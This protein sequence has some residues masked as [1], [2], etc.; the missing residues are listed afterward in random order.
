VAETG[1]CKYIPKGVVLSI[2]QVKNFGLRLRIYGEDG[3]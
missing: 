3:K 1:I 2:N